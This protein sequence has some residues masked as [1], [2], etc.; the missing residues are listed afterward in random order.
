MRS[1]NSSPDVIRHLAFALFGLTGVSL[2]AAPK[3]EK[4]TYRPTGSEAT[5]VGT[6]FFNGTPPEPFRIDPSA[7]PICETLKADLT[8]DSV[9]VTD[10]KLANVVVYVRGESL[11]A[12]SFNALSPD[13]TLEHKGCQYVPHVLGMQTQQTLK[14]VNSD[15]TTHSTRATAKNNPDWNQ[16]Q[17][18]GAP[19]LEQRFSSPELFV[20]LKDNHHPWEKAYVGVFSNPFFSVSGTDGSYRVSGLPPGQYTIIAWHEKFGEQTVD[21]FLAGSEQKNLDFTFKSTAH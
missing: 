6:I 5:V 19:A 15:P 8:T 16:T 20:P 1:T 7:D 10:H 17:P 4:P 3:Q 21:L 9:V 18:P 12:Y 2:I 11:N 13:V 14:I